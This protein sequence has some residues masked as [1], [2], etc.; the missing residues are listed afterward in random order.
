MSML[1]LDVFRRTQLVREPFEHCIMPWFIR[2]E[3]LNRIQSDYP[4]I[5]QGGSFPLSKLR[6]GPAFQALSQELLGPEMQAVF[7]EKFQIDLTGRPATLTVRGQ[8]RAK[9]GQI[10]VDSKTKLIT[11]LLY[12]NSPWEAAGG[13]LRLLCSAH[14]IDNYFAEVP[15]EQGT[16]LC[17]RNGP[18]AWHGHKTFI[19]QRRVL[20]LNWVVSEAAAQA[21]ARRHGLSALLKRFNPFQR[22]AQTTGNVELPGESAAPAAAQAAFAAARW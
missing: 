20:Q 2:P 11:V 18:N 4:E 12:L 19:G 22:G 10:H 7:A 5:P 1:N 15:P 6:F 8:S 13:R 16:L 17:F 9:D 14:D 21:A 3:A